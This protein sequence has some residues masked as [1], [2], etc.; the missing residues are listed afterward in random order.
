MSHGLYLLVR[1]TVDELERVIGWG[2]LYYPPD[3]RGILAG[4]FDALAGCIRRLPARLKERVA[5]FPLEESGE[6]EP[7]RGEVEFYFESIGR[8]VDRDLERL[9]AANLRLASG[10]LA[11]AEDVERLCELAADLKGKF[12]S[13]I[14]GATAALVA[15]G[16]W[17]SF[18]AEVVLFPERAEDA[19]LSRELA[20]ALRAIVDCLAELYERVPLA[21]IVARWRE[22][23]GKA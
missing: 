22:G 2:L 13:A 14:M 11:T 18:D 3:D 7:L 17:Q 1:D 19:R 20:T 4:R 21:R 15:L 8:M 5:A 9:E 16:R 10:E 6:R 12:A 23:Q